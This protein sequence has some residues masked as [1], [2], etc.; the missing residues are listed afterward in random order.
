MTGEGADEIFGGYAAFKT[1]MLLHGVNRSDMMSNQM[2][3]SVLAN[4]DLFKG[5]IIPES[6]VSHAGFNE[7]CGFTPTWIQPWMLV[8]EH[9]KVLLVVIFSRK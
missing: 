7:V 1:D 2:L 5:S 3:Q 6:A 9:L 8:W 4:N